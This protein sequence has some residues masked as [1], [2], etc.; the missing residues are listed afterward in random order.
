MFIDL[1]LSNK[2]ILK[3]I[4]L[5]EAN[6]IAKNKRSNLV[7]IYKND[8]RDVYKLYKVQYKKKKVKKKKLKT[9]K[10]ST[11]IFENDYINKIRFIKKSIVKN[12]IKVI[13]TL[14]GREKG[15]KEQNNLFLDKI[16][17]DL[18]N[19]CSI[20]KNVNDKTNLYSLM[21]TYDKKKN[22]QKS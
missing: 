10:L 6:N 18:E 21:L 9:I 15:N 12:N 17:K 1:V 19:L 11:R 16:A 8:E 5:E 20:K 7:K 14:R 2:E 13:I 4:S 3:N 22:K